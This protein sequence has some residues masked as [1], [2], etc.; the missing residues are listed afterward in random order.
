MLLR[1]GAVYYFCKVVPRHARALLG[2][3]EILV[4]LHTKDIE[5]AKRKLAHEA[6]KANRLIE[7]ARLTLQQNPDAAVE[8]MAQKIA[9]DMRTNSRVEPETWTDEAGGGARRKS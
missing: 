1:R 5:E 2:R 8:R 6:V 3:R 7:G 9:R 4:S